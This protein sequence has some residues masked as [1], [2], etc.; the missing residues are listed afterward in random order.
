[1]IIMVEIKFNTKRMPIEEVD[2]QDKRAHI[3]GALILEI[4]IYS[5]SYPL[6]APFVRPET[7]YF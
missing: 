3:A 2:K 7:I 6:T 5:P 1:M 4:T